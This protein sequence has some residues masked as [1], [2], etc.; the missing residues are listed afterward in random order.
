MKLSTR[1]YQS[2]KQSG[3]PNM[4]KWHIASGKDKLDFHILEIQ[5]IFKIKAFGVQEKLRI[6]RGTSFPS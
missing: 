1:N 6:A 5:R 2:M 3:P 4:H